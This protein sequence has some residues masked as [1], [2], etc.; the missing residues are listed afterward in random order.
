MANILDISYPSNSSSTDDFRVSFSK[1]L[2]SGVDSNFF[3][4]I[5]AIG[6]GMAVSQ[7]GGL[8]NIQSGTT[9]NSETVIRS[10]KAFSNDVFFRY[11][12]SMSQRIANHSV[13]VELVDIIGDGLSV[14]I[15]STTTAVV[16]IPNNPFTVDN[17]GQSMYVANYTGAATFVS[18]RYPIASVSGNDVTFTVSGF[19]TGTG[20]VSLFGYNYHHVLY[21]GTTVT[22]AK[23]DTQRKG[24]AGGDSVVSINS[25]TAPGHSGIISIVNGLAAYQDHGAL[26]GTASIRSDRTAN[27]PVDVDK[28]F[29]QFRV[30]NG[31]AAP[32]STTLASI[33]YVSVINADTPTVSIA[34]VLPTSANTPLPVNIQ[35][36]SVNLGT[37]GTGATSLGKAEDAV[38]ASGDTGV[39]ILGVRVTGTPTVQTSAVGDYGFPALNSEGKVIVSN[40]AADELSW[41]A[42]PV[43]LTTTASTALKAAAPAGIRN[44][45]TDVTIANTSA[46]GVRVDVLDNATVIRSFWSPPTSTITQ[47]FGM[48]IKSTAATALNVQLSAA[49]TD[50]RVSANGYIGV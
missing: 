23:Y 13:F 39:A 35:S 6:T 1:N 22:S 37:G 43:T 25:T 17:I 49:V 2:P 7:S 14:N 9:A 27:I 40:F 46:T 47:A 34:G 15:T 32:A 50:V 3:K 11:G 10:N 30:L 8:L 41:Q 19:T 21:D 18:G 36:G 38:S 31:P 26:G 12:L 45:L 16:T 44:Y 20:T 48:S 5:P 4:I 33:N 28:L 42:N 29:I 24:Y